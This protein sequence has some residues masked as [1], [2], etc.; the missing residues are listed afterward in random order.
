MTVM[1]LQLTGWM[2]PSLACLV[3]LCFKQ[4]QPNMHSG[5]P[6]WREPLLELWRPEQTQPSLQN[7]WPHSVSAALY[8]GYRGA[9]GSWL[10][11]VWFK[12]KER[13]KPFKPF[14][15]HVLHVTCQCRCVLSI[16]QTLFSAAP[17]SLIYISQNRKPIINIKWQSTH[18]HTEYTCIVCCTPVLSALQTEH[19][20]VCLQSVVFCP[21]PRSGLQSPSETVWAGS[22]WGLKFCVLPLGSA[23]RSPLVSG[24]PLVG[25]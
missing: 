22:W 3:F 8:F 24:W 14:P 5:W 15:K 12:W 20:I 25:M 9:F 17:H 11:S 7:S 19:M 16:N 13:S 10:D 2:P 6:Q 21:G 23:H 1:I 18:R 4:A